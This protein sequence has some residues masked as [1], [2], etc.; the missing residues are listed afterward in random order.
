MKNIRWVVTRYSEQDQCRVLVR[1]TNSRV[2]FDTAV[3]AALA[4]AR[5]RQALEQTMGWRG[6]EIR[7][8]E[9][10][11]TAD[12]KDGDPK[13][14]WFDIPESADKTG[15]YVPDFFPSDIYLGKR[16]PV[17]LDTFGKA[18]AEDAAAVLIVACQVRGKWLE[19]ITIPDIDHAIENDTRIKHWLKNPYFDVDYH[20]LVDLDAIH[21]TMGDNAV[22]RLQPLFFECLKRHVQLYREHNLQYNQTSQWINEGGAIIPEFSNG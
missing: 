19:E 2:T 5:K 22:V 10:W 9:C 18:E 20:L 6:L 3:D 7:W 12:P 1:I 17:L 11:E 15:K 21:M 4:L 13:T 8:V 14:C 16:L